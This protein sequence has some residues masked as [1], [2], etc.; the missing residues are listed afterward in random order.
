MIRVGITGGIGSGKS[1]LVQVWKKL[2]AHVLNADAFARELMV[3]DEDLIQELKDTFGEETYHPDGSLNKE[4][5]IR[6]AFEKGRVGELNGVV[7][8]VLRKRT[9]EYMAKLPKETPVFAYE[10]AVLLNDG[11][12]EGFDCI[13]LLLANAEKRKQWVNKRDRSG[14]KAVMDRMQAQP[15]FEQLQHLADI[16]IRNDGTLE[17]LKQKAENSYLKILED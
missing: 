8:P 15:D 5:L 3:S 2:G 17:E 11:R 7:H 13:L 9:A 4:H 6:E 14:E 1:T 10:A 12:P 16:I